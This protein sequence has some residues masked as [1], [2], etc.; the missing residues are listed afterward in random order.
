MEVDFAE[1]EVRTPTGAGLT[2]LYAMLMDVFEADRPIFAEMI[3]TG[4][5]FYTWTPYALYRGDEVLGNVSLVPMRIRLE[6]R[7][8]EVVGIA[9]VA[10][11]MRYRRMGI[12]THLL[13]HCLRI[14]DGQSRPAVLFTDLPAMYERVEFQV[15]PQSYR[16]AQTGRMDFAGKSLEAR[17]VEKVSGRD[18]E[19]LVRLF[20]ERGATYEGTVVRDGAYWQLYE[21]LF[22]LYTKSKILFFTDAGEPC[23]YARVEVEGDRLLVCEVCGDEDGVA[24]LLGS[25]ADYACEVQRDVITFALSPD[26][27]VWQL[28]E[29]QKVELGPE[30]AGARRETFMVRPAAG[31]ALGA[32]GRLQW[33]LADKF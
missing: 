1:C 17:V 5:P 4:K 6:G 19:Q 23:A 22:N 2:G 20:D 12:A 30:P 14:V 8:R 16:T 26:H 33:S 3:E 25:V 13:G 10:T 32:F 11:P 27:F 7:V 15:I 21:M 29:D 9:S 31:E 28:L 18:I 24:A